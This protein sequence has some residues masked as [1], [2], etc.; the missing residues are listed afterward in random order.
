VNKAVQ[1]A[2]R[3]NSTEPRRFRWGQVAAMPKLRRRMGRI[4]RC[5]ET[6]MSYPSWNNNDNEKA[7]LGFWNLTPSRLS[8]SS[9]TKPMFL[10]TGHSGHYSF[11]DPLRT[12]GMQPRADPGL[13]HTCVFKAHSK[14]RISRYVTFHT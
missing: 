11:Q 10:S 7:F 1:I 4:A 14:Y 5:I 9:F 2:G 13:L 3:A 6:N 8:K 12:Q